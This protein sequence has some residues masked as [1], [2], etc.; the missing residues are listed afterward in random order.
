MCEVFSEFWTEESMDTQFLDREILKAK[1]VPSANKEICVFIKRAKNGCSNVNITL[2]LNH[3]WIHYS[4]CKNVELPGKGILAQHLK[5]PRTWNLIL[6][7]QLTFAMQTWTK[8]VNISAFVFP[9]RRGENESDNRVHVVC[10]HC[11]SHHLIFGDKKNSQGALL[12][13]Q[14][15]QKLTF[16][17]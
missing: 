3:L 11:H 16:L 13:P 1:C 6:Q 10:D 4:S 5:I 2:R 8:D 7:I 17:C 12:A 9:T 15:V 14:V